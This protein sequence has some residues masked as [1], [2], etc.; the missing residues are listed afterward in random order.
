MHRKRSHDDREGSNNRNNRQRT[1]S[2]NNGNNG[3]HVPNPK[4]EY[5]LE[6]A[7]PIINEADTNPIQIERNKRV[8]AGLIGHLGLAKKK[9]EQDSSIIDKQQ[10]IATIVSQKHQIEGKKIADM[11]KKIL[12]NERTKELIRKERLQ[13]D[14]QLNE[15]TKYQEIFI[16]NQECLKCYLTTT[17]YPELLWKP[18]VINGK[19]TEL[20]LNRE[21][22]IYNLILER[23]NK[24]NNNIDFL[25]S[26]LNELEETERE[27]EESAFHELN[28]NNNNNNN[29]T[30]EEIETTM[31][32]EEVSF[33]INNYTES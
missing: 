24:D 13:I 27:I 4:E 8:F 15:I 1:T 19:L 6:T 18:K 16:K 17:T 2:M 25:K 12:E 7:R 11:K 14:K 23:E 31:T 28:H 21:N 32:T 9:L 5:R 33:K 20:T 3:I 30:E 29:N 26:R 22:Q 10:G